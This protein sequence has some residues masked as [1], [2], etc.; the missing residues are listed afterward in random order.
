MKNNLI[1]N[2][3][4]WEEIENFLRGDLP[5]ETLDQMRLK[6]KEDAN[7]SDKVAHVHHLMTGIREAALEADL[8]NISFP[9]GKATLRHIGGN[10]K[11]YQFGW[12][13]AAAIIVAVV[14]FALFNMFNKG[15]NRLFSKYYYPDS[16]LVSSMGVSDN[17][18]FDVAMIDYKSGKYNEAIVEMKKLLHSN[19]DNDT[20]NYFIGNSFLALKKIDSAISYMNVVAID[21]KSTFAKEANWYLGLAY[22]KLGQKSKAASYILRSGNEK[23]DELL[24]QIS[25]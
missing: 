5:D 19:K 8:K 17:Y 7:F 1:I 20:L 3:E 16:G 4:E 11:K 25:K 14:V 10:W 15:E 18:D 24:Q 22:L 2:E 21:S 13:A 23:R 12:M 9:R 6:M